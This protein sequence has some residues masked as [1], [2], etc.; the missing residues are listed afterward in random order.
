MKRL[1]II[2]SGIAAAALLSAC[3]S[4]PKAP[5]QTEL[6]YTI[7]L[8]G[9]SV[10]WLKDNEGERTMPAAMFGASQE[11]IDEIGEQIP[12]S[13]S[14]FLVQD[15]Q[16]NYLFDAGMGAPDSNLLWALDT[17]GVSTDDIG[18]IFITHLHGDHIGGLVNDG[19]DVFTNAEVYLARTEY[20]AFINGPQAPGV[21]GLA[22]AYGE[23][24]HLFEY[25]DELPGGFKAMHIPGHTPGH[26]AYCRGNLLL[27]GD[28]MHGVALQTVHPELNA[29][30]DQDSTA[31]VASR[32]MILDL[33]PD[34]ILAGSHFPEPRFIC[35]A[36]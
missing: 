10:T 29:R 5:M 14:A 33:A 25:D 8:D 13:T 27:V 36:E 7:E 34:Y 23:R 16:G 22:E 3:A 11:I 24:L 9:F 35:P 19:A 26:T 6:T 30:F 21:Q 12:A 31:S 32:R 20:E 18:Y 1:S 17:L 2:L 15:K 4:E 28:I